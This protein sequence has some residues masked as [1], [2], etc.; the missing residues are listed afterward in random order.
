MVRLIQVIRIT[1]RVLIQNELSS[2]HKGV[3]LVQDT[4]VNPEEYQPHGYSYSSNKQESRI[5]KSKN[6]ILTFVDQELGVSSP[7]V[8]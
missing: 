3:L 2:L 6:T 5:T 7:F 4:Q 1:F 8:E